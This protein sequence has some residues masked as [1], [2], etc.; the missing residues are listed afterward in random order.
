MST[1]ESPSFWFLPTAQSLDARRTAM[2]G[3]FAFYVLSAGIGCGTLAAYNFGPIPFDYISRT[4]LI[5]GAF[6]MLIAGVLPKVA[7]FTPAWLLLLWALIGTFGGLMDHRENLFMPIL[8]Q[9]YPIFIALRFFNLMAALSCAY[10]VVAACERYSFEKVTKFAVWLGTLVSL[11]AIYAYAAQIFGLPDILRNRAGTGGAAIST[12]FTYAFHRALGTFREPS[13]LAE[14]LL[15]PIFVSLAMRNRIMNVHSV[16]MMFVLLLTGSLSGYGG[17]LAGLGASALF[18]NPL[19]ASSWKVL[20]AILAVFG[21]GLVGFI[22]FASGKNIDVFTL[23]DVVWSR[24][25]PILQ[26]GLGK[27][28]RG[29]VLHAVL[30]EDISMFGYGFGRAN[31]I[32]SNIYTAGMPNPTLFVLSYISLYFHYL[33]ATGV[34][35]LT[36]LLFFVF[37]PVYQFWNHK[38]VDVRRQYSFLAGGIVAFAV[39]NTLL[40]DEMPPEFALMIG[41]VIAT[42]RLKGRQN[43]LRRAKLASQFTEL[44]PVSKTPS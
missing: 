24:V 19:R 43:S 42:V 5:A 32:L 22:I 41:L 16:L 18:A 28:D 34:V 29:D 40:F 12:T 36:L 25:L 14:W 10:L 26:G 6:T 7:A 38:V 3:Q 13:H 15:A 39:T 27:S 23:F 1:H 30:Q 9:P 44:T 20:G 31:I 8:S 35:G 37:A 4:L 2:W 21:V 33:Y 17:F 11:Y